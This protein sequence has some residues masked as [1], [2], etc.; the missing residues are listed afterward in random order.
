MT[1]MTMHFV[2]PHRAARVMNGHGYSMLR[3]GRR[4]V[5]RL[6]AIRNWTAQDRANHYVAQMPIAVLVH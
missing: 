2:V 5:D 3:V 1:T 6:G 4:L